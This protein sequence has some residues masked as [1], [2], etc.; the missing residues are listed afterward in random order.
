VVSA[1]PSMWVV[2]NYAVCQKVD[3]VEQLSTFSTASAP[4]E[5]KI[6]LIEKTMACDSP[7]VRK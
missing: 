4:C 2:S 1:N 7:H 5:K 3:A 6:A